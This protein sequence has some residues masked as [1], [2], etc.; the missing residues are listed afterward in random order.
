MSFRLIFTLFACV[1]LPMPSM[2]TAPDSRPGLPLFDVHSH[3]TEEDAEVFPAEQIAARLDAAGIERMVVIGR[4]PEL[5]LR[6]HRAAPERVV[7]FLGAYR[8]TAEKRDWALDLRLPARMRAT[9]LEAGNTPADGATNI[10]HKTGRFRGIGE[11]HLFAPM[12]KS[13]VFRQVLAL[14][15][16]F[17][18]PV[19]LHGDAEIV[20]Q[21]FEW[22]PNL[23]VIW[24]HLGTL[25]EPDRVRSMLRKHPQQ[26]FVD[27]SVRD[28]RFTDEN[29]L[30]RPEW[31]SLFIDHQDRLLAAVDTFSSS[32]WQRLHEVSGQIRHW[33]GQLPQP[34]AE[35]LARGNAK[36]LFGA[37]ARH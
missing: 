11:L 7:P 21:A 3:F 20:D 4:P 27:T 35:K 31:R 29:G 26:L 9:L 23:T 34:V 1:T 30:L 37:A 5:A 12:R 24:A 8:N 25:P 17:D 16:E 36:R 10:E 33:L 32:R 22:Q 28:E 14:A 2:G 15:A 18:L 13:P 6:L 19:L